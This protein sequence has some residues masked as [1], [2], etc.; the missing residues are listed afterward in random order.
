MKKRVMTIISICMFLLVACSNNKESSENTTKGTD[1][2][3]VN[4]TTTTETKVEVSSESNNIVESVEE[5]N[6]YKVYTDITGNTSDIDKYVSDNQIDKD[7][8]AEFQQATTTQEFVAVE[9]KYIDL[10]K[11]EMSNIITQLGTVLDENDFCNFKTSQD[12]WEKQLFDTT[13][14]DLDIVQNDQ[15]EIMIGSSFRWLWLSNIREE[16]R[17]RTIHINYMLY[18]IQSKGEN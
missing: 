15:Y 18:L 11:A 16:Y 17:E 10:W 5:S 14:S 2:V 7:Y 6:N 9:N 4:V 3:V 1:D 13:Q 12:E 8:Y